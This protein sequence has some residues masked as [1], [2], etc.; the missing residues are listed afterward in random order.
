M[1]IHKMFIYAK[2]ALF[3]KSWLFDVGQIDYLQK[4]LQKLNTRDS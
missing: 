3:G 1:Y 2:L 4:R